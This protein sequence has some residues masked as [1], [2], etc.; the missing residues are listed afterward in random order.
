[1]KEYSDHGTHQCACLPWLAVNIARAGRE[2]AALARFA[3]TGLA[4]QR[5]LPTSEL[6]GVS[7]GQEWEGAEEVE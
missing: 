2:E 6:P 5:G 1:M 3:G 7:A 4:A